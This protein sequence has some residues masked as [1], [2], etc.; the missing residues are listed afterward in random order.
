MAQWYVEFHGEEPTD[1]IGT[2]VEAETGDDAID[3]AREKVA[4]ERDGENK[5]L[6]HGDD[7]TVYD[8]RTKYVART[9]RLF[10]E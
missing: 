6:L 5:D 7:E 8:F 1:E 9:V 10:V 3:V 4:G 2:V